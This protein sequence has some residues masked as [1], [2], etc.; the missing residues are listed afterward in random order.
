MFATRSSLPDYCQHK[1]ECTI[2]T[3]HAIFAIHVKQQ[4]I[5]KLSS[6]DDEKRSSDNINSYE[7]EMLTAKFNFVDLAG[8]ERLLKGLVLLATVQKKAF[9]STVVCWPWA[10]SSVLWEIQQRRKTMY[11][12]EIPSLQDYYRIPLEETAARS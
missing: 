8:S 11:L 9:Q 4:R 3:I 1:H 6:D 12:T 2:I 5:V 7:Y 10:M